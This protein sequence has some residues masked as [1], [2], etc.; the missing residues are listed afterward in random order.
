[1]ARKAGIEWKAVGASLTDLARACQ[2]V[3][4]GAASAFALANSGVAQQAGVIFLARY[5]TPANYAKNT[6]Q[7]V[8]FTEPPGATHGPIVRTNKDESGNFIRNGKGQFVYVAKERKRF[9]KGKFVS[10]SG[11]MREIAADLAR[12]PPNDK[13]GRTITLGTN[14][15]KGHTG[16][17]DISIEYDGR[18]VFS[19][20]GGYAA[21]EKG[22]RSGRPMGVKGW[23]RSIRGASGR[24]STLIKKKYPDLI[25][26]RKTGLDK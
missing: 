3:P 14:P 26:I 21:A 8:E 20:D 12:T 10:R 7:G 17:I 19:I 11:E 13:P 2:A 9:I 25:Q 16:D 15:R 18:C 6:A 5:I 22:S 4:R 24:W 23:F 1:M